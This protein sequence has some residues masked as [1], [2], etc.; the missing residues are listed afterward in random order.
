MVALSVLVGTY[1][2]FLLEE[3][4]SWKSRMCVLMDGDYCWLPSEGTVGIW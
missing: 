1:K 4:R 2:E 3:K